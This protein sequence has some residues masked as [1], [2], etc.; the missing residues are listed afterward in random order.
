MYD[1]IL[2]TCSGKVDNLPGGLIT[3]DEV[4]KACNTKL[5]AKKY[6]GHDRVLNGH[7]KYGGKNWCNS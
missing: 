5:E 1:G 3:G 4:S 2:R 7:I 6:P